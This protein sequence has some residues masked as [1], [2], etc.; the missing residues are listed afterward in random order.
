MKQ[1]I[2]ILDYGSGNVKSV[3]NICKFIGCDV[4]ISNHP[5]EIRSRSHIILPGVGAYGAS[6]E[7]IK[8]SIPLE[9]LEYEVINK[10]KPFL[11]ICVGMQVLSDIGLEYGKHKGLGWIPGTVK[12][13]DNKEEPTIHVGWNNIVESKKSELTKNIDQNDNFYF[14]HSFSFDLEN[15]DYLLCETKYGTVFPSIISKENIFGVQFHPEKSQNS[16]IKI[17]KNFLDIE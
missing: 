10:N 1:T 11:G 6:V 3:F 16:G 13:H 12:K 9:I 7:K 5:E 14:V 15:K 17:F 4:I 2:C 8:R